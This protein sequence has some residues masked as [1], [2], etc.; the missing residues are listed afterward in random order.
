[1]LGFAQKI[2]ALHKWMG[3]LLFPWV[4]IYGLTGLYMNHG[5]MVLSLFPAD[6]IDTEI[7]E[8]APGLRADAEAARAWL[9]TQP[10]ASES[11]S[12][13]EGTYHGAPAWFIMLGDNS[14][15]VAFKNSA[16]WVLRAPYHRTLH[17]ADGSVEDTRYYWDRILADFHKRGLVASPFGSLLADA[18]SVI[19]IGFGVSG[20]LVWVLPRLNRLLIR[21]R[22]RPSQ[23]NQ[24]VHKRR[25]TT[26]S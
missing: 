13:K 17:A 1:M 2:R 20:L 14:E 26:P 24:S 25:A 3:L 15:V 8:D 5:K 23:T 19:L 11:R 6:R 21:L 12:L 16:Q 4:I 22:H 18:F 9:R 7:I 10:F